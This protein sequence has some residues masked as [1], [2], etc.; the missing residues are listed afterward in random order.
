MPLTAIAL[1]AAKKKEKAYKLYDEKGLYVL[2]NTS[3]Q[4]YFRFD[5]RIHGKRKTLALGVYPDVSLSDAREKRDDARKLIAKE[6]DPC[7]LKRN[8]KREKFIRASNSFE[9]VA[10]EWISKQSGTW[11]KSHT[12]KVLRRLEKD[13]FPLIGGKPVAN[14]TAPELLALLRKIEN[15]GAVDTAHRA[16][17]NCSQVFRYAIATDRAERDPAAD[18]L[19][20][21]SSIKK[22]HFPTITE[23]RKIGELLRAIDGYTGSYVVGY[24]L[25]LAPL[26]FV[27]PGELRNA[28]W[29][30]FDME[31]FEWRIPAE[32]MKMK[33]EH[34]VP[35]SIQAIKF[36]NELYNYTGHGRYLFPS[37]RT[38]SRPMSDNTVNAALRRLGYSSDEMTGHGFRAMAST[39]LHEKGWSSDIIERQLA[40]GERNQVKAAYNHAEYLPERR[41]MMQSWADYLDGVK[42]TGK[43]IP[44]RS[45]ASE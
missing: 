4:K 10:R 16:K 2:V 31:R 27:R 20:A 21:L 43:V 24:A 41:K 6:V 44:L 32:K 15:R 1:K 40:H 9:A 34:I 12:E 7:E 35:L 30:E 11:S 33:V 36:I 45:A 5:F 23:P 37:V 17:Q 29:A 18:L 28:E 22:K 42:T 13:I 25:Q 39:S 38:E 8:K 26:L 3:G 14:I 19:G